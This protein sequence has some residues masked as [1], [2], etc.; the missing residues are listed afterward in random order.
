MMT[1][2]QGDP[3]QILILRLS[4]L[5]DIVHALPVSQALRTR[6]P[7]ARI[8][9]LTRERYRGLLEMNPCLDEV[10]VLREQ[11][12]WDILRMI[13]QIRQGRYDVVFDLHATVTSHLLA[14]V[15]GTPV[16]LGVDKRNDLGFQ[17]FTR[18]RLPKD[19]RLHRVQV[20]LDTLRFLGVECAEAEFPIAIPT[21]AQ[22]RIE[23]FFR[24]HAVPPRELLVT[25]H[26]GTAVGIKRWSAGNFAALAER[27][28]AEAGVRVVLVHG[29]RDEPLPGG[30]GQRI[31]QAPL[32]SLPEL[33]ALLR[34]SDLVIG[35][36]S[37]PL[38]LAAALGRPTAMIFGPSDP[39]VTGPYGSGHL[40]I[41]EELPCSPCYDN[42]R[43]QFFCKKRTH[44]C[45]R[46]LT[47]ERVATE[48]KAHLANRGR[49]VA[50]SQGTSGSTV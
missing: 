15:S 24:E 5:G 20:Y 10:L 33:A 39:Q 18:H 37:G 14:G 42:F 35:N 11:R 48:I 12:P 3:R 40:V 23:Q 38:Q 45:L 13:R 4:S 8:T 27:L 31:I 1:G 21:S 2:P 19:R 17:M 32:L 26:P 44:A 22:H 41:R 25:I 7:Q 49:P 6:F 28:A 34:R 50:A 46:N 43:I 47:V 9:W 16:K 36:D 30:P 29:E